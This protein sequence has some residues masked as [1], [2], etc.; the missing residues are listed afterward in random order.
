ML[1][2]DSQAGRESADREHIG[3]LAMAPRCPRL[4]CI[5]WTKEDLVTTH[6]LERVRLSLEEAAAAGESLWRNP[7]ANRTN[8]AVV[9]SWPTFSTRIDNEAS[10]L[11]PLTH[12][13]SRLDQLA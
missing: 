10:M 1:V 7:P 6:G 8:S 4:G 2:L 11:A 3:A 12:V 13:I 5:V 9:A